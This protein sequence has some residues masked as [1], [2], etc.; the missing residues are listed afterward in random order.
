MIKITDR[1]FN[2]PPFLITSWEH[3][4]SLEGH[5]ST[6]SQVTLTFHM[7]SG[8][9]VELPPLNRETADLAFKS[10]LNYQDQKNHLKQRLKHAFASSL[11]NNPLSNDPLLNLQSSLFDG[12][13]LT[14]P[15]AQQQTNPSPFPSIDQI[16]SNLKHNPEMKDL[17]AMPYE[18]LK[19][20]A[21]TARDIFGRDTSLELPTPH[22][23]CHC[24]HCQIARA[25]H[26]G[27]EQAGSEVQENELRFSNWHIH[28]L[29]NDHFLVVN[30]SNPSEC[31]DVKL[32][33]KI[34]CS[35]QMSTCAHIE[36]VLRS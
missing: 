4:S 17:P 18:L 33:P 6:D 2:F 16:A 13:F 29:K 21:Q 30:T 7:T 28:L 3:V 25:I 14:L 35:C 36:A 8:V 9:C 24:M 23:G 20:I 11:L 27:M 32:K 34:E 31:F 22:T 1:L 15:L 26:I 5:L 12:S 19:K 10:F